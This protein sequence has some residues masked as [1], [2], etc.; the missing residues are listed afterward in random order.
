[1]KKTFQKFAQAT[2]WNSNLAPIPARLPIAII[3][4]GVA[5]TPLWAGVL[6]WFLFHWLVGQ[7]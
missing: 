7:F 4:I 3:A 5:I 1:M 6:V 2:A